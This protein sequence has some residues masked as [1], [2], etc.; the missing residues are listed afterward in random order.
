MALP[1]GKHAAIIAVF[2]AWAILAVFRVRSILAF[3][4][5]TILLWIPISMYLNALFFRYRP[6]FLKKWEPR[7]QS[8]FKRFLERQ[9]E[10][11]EPPTLFDKKGN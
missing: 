5:G 10:R 1:Y 9:H 8:H 3:T 7:K 6:P 4:I 2:V 11:D